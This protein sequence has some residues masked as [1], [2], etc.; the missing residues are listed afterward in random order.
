[1]TLKK[2]TMLEPLTYSPRVRLR[3]CSVDVTYSNNFTASANQPTVAS[4]PMDFTFYVISWVSFALTVF[5]LAALAITFLTY[6]L[7]E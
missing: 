6:C 3:F 5:T 7:F 4:D 2:A 1:V